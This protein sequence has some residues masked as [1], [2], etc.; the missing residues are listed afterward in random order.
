MNHKELHINSQ[1]ESRSHRKGGFE[2]EFN[3]STGSL[4]LAKLSKDSKDKQKFL[5]QQD[6]TWSLRDKFYKEKIPILAFLL[7]FYS[8]G[9]IFFKRCK[10]TNQKMSGFEGII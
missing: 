2:M 3:Y 6:F 9:D 8:P 1:S 10:Q 4:L 7:K 5:G